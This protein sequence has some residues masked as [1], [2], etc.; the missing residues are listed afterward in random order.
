MRN[1]YTLNYRLLKLSRLLSLHRNLI[2]PVFVIKWFVCVSGGSTSFDVFRLY[3][4]NFSYAWVWLKQTLT[5]V[6]KVK[7][8]FWYLQKLY[9]AKTLF[10]LFSFF[11]S[12]QTPFSPFKFEVWIII[13]VVWSFFV[14]YPL[15]SGFFSSQ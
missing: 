2:F 1:Y 12:L 8:Y 5:I 9:V 3:Y 7:F 11:P 14:L 10:S 4:W 15:C 6:E 13:G